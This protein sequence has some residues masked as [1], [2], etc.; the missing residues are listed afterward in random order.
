[1][2]GP[3]PVLSPAGAMSPSNRCASPPQVRK[4]LKLVSINY[5]LKEEE[6]EILSLLGI[7]GDYLSYH[8]S[9]SG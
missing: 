5:K 4:H 2:T 6:V 3:G 8:F 9:V 1:M 7:F